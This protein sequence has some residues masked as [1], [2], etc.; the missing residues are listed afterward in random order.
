MTSGVT[1]SS[2]RIPIATQLTYVP[3]SFLDA[4]AKLTTEANDFWRGLVAK[5]VEVAEVSPEDPVA[6]LGRASLRSAER[7]LAL[8]TAA[9][10]RAPDL[11]AQH[12]REHGLQST[13]N[14]TAVETL[15]ALFC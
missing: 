14:G 8:F 6:Q 15:A 1:A 13:D 12:F 4:E 11:V 3:Q 10:K 5:Y 9:Q 7:R 2:F